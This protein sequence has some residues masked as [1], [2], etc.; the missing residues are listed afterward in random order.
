VMVAKLNGVQSRVLRRI[1]GEMRYSAVSTS[2]SDRDVRGSLRAMSIDCLIQRARL[3]YVA[4]VSS[5]RC[6]PLLALL[7][8][9]PRG[10]P[11]PW[12]QQV[13]VDFNALYNFVPDVRASLPKPT[14]GGALQ[15]WY[16][17][18]KLKPSAW[19]E[20]V[21]QLRFIDSCIDKVKV[22]ESLESVISSHVCGDCNA[23]FASSKALLCHCRTIHGYRDPV[24]LYVQADGVCP[25]CKSR[26]HSRLRAIAHVNDRR[27][28]S[29]KPQLLSGGFVQIPPKLADELDDFDRIA[30]KEARHQGHSHPIAV[31]SAR[32]VSGKRVGHVTK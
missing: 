12:T 2:L 10:Q 8:S 27:N 21:D 7:R 32:K 28:K 11:L 13:F 18:I 3:K 16:R 25:V 23:A 24:R 17:F 26:F 30:R 1:C 20:L 29:C 14:L 6:R 4:R 15:D 31:Q 9:R 5:S 22:S 19:S